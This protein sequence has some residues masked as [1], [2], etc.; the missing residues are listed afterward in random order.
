MNSFFRQL[1]QVWRQPGFLGLLSANFAQGMAY[2]F[3]VPFMSK[4][5]TQYV[6]MSEFF[7]GVFMT[8]TSLCAIVFSTILARWSDAHIARRTMILIGGT[9]GMLGY[10]GYAFVSNPWIL[11]ACGCLLLS[12]ASVNFSQIFA[13]L[14]EELDRPENRHADAP[15]LLSIARVFFSLAW[16]VGPS[17]GA[18]VKNRFDYPGSFLAASG[19]FALFLVLVHLYIPH[20]QHAPIHYQPPKE[21]IWSVLRRPVILFSSIGF[22]LYF[23][24]H[25]M[26][27]M[28]LPLLVTGELGGNFNDVGFI[29]GIA[30]VVEIPLMIWSGRLAAR[31]H[32][33]ALLRLGAI[34]GAL[35]FLA[36][37]FV[38]APYH[39]YPMQI[40][41]AIAIG[42]LTN[43]TITFFQDQLPSQVGLAGS[44][45]SNTFNIGS[46]LGYFTF[47]VA[48]PRVGDRGLF[49]VCVAFTTIT[50]LILLRIRH[51][52]PAGRPRTADA[53]SF[54]G[55]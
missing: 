14:R 27:M 4:W 6:G 51:T 47:G 31:G 43:I 17:L 2:S 1:P 35:Y 24:S 48:V 52:T 38:H 50:V 33:M 44:I 21:P 10:A 46:L 23:A 26:S 55:H 16:I 12:L 37:T 32:M 20:R 15:F 28:A 42:I 36:L 13:H 11:L 5:G 3:V 41:S 54:A 19:L 18:M 40:L 9:G 45:Y 34:A 8:L 39:I 53:T 30:P 25:S 49:W 29:Y 7:F 22:I